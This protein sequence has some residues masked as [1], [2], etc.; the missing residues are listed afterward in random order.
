MEN[1]KKFQNFKNIKKLLIIFLLIFILFMC[2]FIYSNIS[3]ASDYETNL[4]EKTL[5]EIKYFESKIIYIFNSL[6][7][8]EFE[9]YKL[10]VEDISEKSKN[11]SKSS[12]SA[13][14][15]KGDESSKSEDNSSKEDEATSENS[16]T[17]NDT[18]KYSLNARGVLTNKETINWEYIKNE[19]ELLQESISTMILDLYEISLNSNDILNFNKE[20]D[21]LLVQIKNEN[22][23]GSLKSLSI[24]YSYIPKFIKNCNTDDQY[25]IIINTKM[26]I[27]NA[28]SLLD[29][30][31]W[32]EVGKYV[33]SANNSFSRLLTDVNIENKNQP[34]INRCY[35][36]LN[37]LQNAVNTQEKEI[38]L[39]KYKNLLEELNNI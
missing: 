35:I 8:I 38:F 17:I 29:T 3:K 20:Y 5:S 23:E 13:G 15:S 36:L 26:N 39:I 2:F 4:R 37:S 10:S 34:T 21:N 18:K 19:A 16:N 30:E 24:L 9:N 31:H 22:K 25:K 33:E 6:N 1:L 14:S 28:Y 11:S 12:E 32:E 27:F 7:N